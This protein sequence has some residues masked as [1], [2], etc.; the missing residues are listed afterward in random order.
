MRAISC[1]IDGVKVSAQ[2]IRDYVRREY[3]EPARRSKL[4]TVR[5]VAGDVHKAVRLH[6]RVPLVCQA[7]RGRKFL[8]EN[9]MILEKLEGP[10]SGLS[11]TVAFT[12]RLMDAD[13]G[14]LDASE[15]FPFVRLR[16]I[17]KEVFRQLGGGEQFIRNERA[18]FYGEES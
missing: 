1:Y 2:Q 11:T 4:R 7:L 3:I 14:R 5:V 8:E 16:G 9:R 13:A 6:N 12:Y 17:A 10:Q 18:H 15:E